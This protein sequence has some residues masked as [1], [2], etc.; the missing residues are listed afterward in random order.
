MK[1]HSFKPELKKIQFWECTDKT[2]TWFKK[3]NLNQEN[4]IL[5]S[6]ENKS[7]TKKLFSVYIFT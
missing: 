7:L 4:N 1:V 6:Q 5:F 2:F 3:K